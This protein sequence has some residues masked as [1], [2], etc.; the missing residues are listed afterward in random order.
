[1]DRGH[2]E[3]LLGRNEAR[4]DERAAFGSHREVG[5]GRPAVGADRHPYACGP[6]V[7]KRRQPSAQRERRARTDHEREPRAMP[8]E[9]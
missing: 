5:I 6:E 3:R 7:V 4:I 2:R 1:M 9:A 8:R